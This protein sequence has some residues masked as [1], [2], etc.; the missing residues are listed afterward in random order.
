[1]KRATAF[2]SVALAAV[3]TLSLAACGSGDSKAKAAK[4]PSE[5]ITMIV[6][7]SA[8]GGT[9]LAARALGDAASGILGVPVT[10]TNITGGNGSVGVTELANG[11]KDGY[12]IGVATLSPLALV[13]WQ[14]DVTYKPENFQYICAFGQYGYGIVVNA[15]SDIKTLDDLV[16]LAKGK[17][18]KYGYT[19]YPQPFTMAE[20]AKLSGTQ[21]EG[22]SYSSTTDLITDILGGFIPVAMAD[23]ASF[24]SYV[25]SGQMRLLASATDQRWAPAPDVATLREA[26]Y[27][28][29]CD[30]YMGLCAPAGIAP[31]QLAVLR[32]AFKKA[33][34]TDTYKTV[35]G[36]VNMAWVYKSGE[37]YEKMVKDKYAEYKAL[38]G[39]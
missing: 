5:P 26:G 27:D 12:T 3:M 14:L 17:S 34:E 18:V 4:Y 20:F 16:K 19:G 31:E 6:N 1:M 39:K 9:D 29:V 38:F 36:N 30:S 37:E 35:I 15:N 22:V 32:D 21:F 24:T 7:Y 25:K 8:G 11:K 13:P 10:V 28:T 23:Q 2:A 33:A